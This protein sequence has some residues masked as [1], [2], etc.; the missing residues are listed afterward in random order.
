MQL[1][2]Y[3]KLGLLDHGKRQAK[4]RSASRAIFDVDFKGHILPFDEAAAFEYA[5]I[6]KRRRAIGRPIIQFD[7]QI[8][9]IAR[10]RGSKLATRNVEDFADCGVDLI[11]PWETDS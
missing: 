3:C 6:A 7:A 10:S 1:Y 2:V 8:A 9:A 11:N 4:L 5:S